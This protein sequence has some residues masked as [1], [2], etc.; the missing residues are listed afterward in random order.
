M[1]KFHT[2]YSC[3]GYFLLNFYSLQNIQPCIRLAN[4]PDQTVS[5]RLIAVADVMMDLSAHFQA[6]RHNPHIP[7]STF[8]SV[9]VFHLG[10]LFLPRK[11]QMQ[12]ISF[13]QEQG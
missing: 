2:Q 7:A 10:C 6:T 3:I 13:M 1:G 4:V 5:M 9:I 11:S 12:K 8:Y